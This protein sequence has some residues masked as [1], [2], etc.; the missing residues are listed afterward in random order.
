MKN[1]IL[2]LA[3]C[4]V[5]ISSFAVHYADPIG[6]V[7]NSI[8]GLC[9]DISTDLTSN[10]IEETKDQFIVTMTMS[11]KIIRNMGYREY[12][13]WIDTHPGVHAGYRPYLPYSVAWPNLFAEYRIF[14][15]L[16]AD[17]PQNVDVQKVTMQNCLTSNCENDQGMRMD[18]NLK[19]EIKGS[20][21]IFTWPKSLIPDLQAAKK[22]KIGFTT[23]YSYFQCSG[24]DDSPQWGKN[25]LIYDRS[26]A[27]DSEVKPVKPLP[28]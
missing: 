5:S 15:S 7:D 14:L 24:E 1:L 28:K 27:A 16:T 20:Q 21:I 23:Y 22:W 9:H 12:Y 2:I 26:N 6:D 19:A 13:F 4:L 8:K 25:A 18:Q 10:Q 17:A 11:Q 3:S